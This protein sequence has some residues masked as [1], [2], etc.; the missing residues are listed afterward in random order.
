MSALRIAWFAPNAGNWVTFRMEHQMANALVD[1]GHDV[2]MVQCDEV[3]NAYCQVMAPAGLAAT[4]SDRDKKVVCRECRFAAGL[5]RDAARYRTAQLSEF[6]QP[7]D[8]VQADATVLAQTDETWRDLV[9]AGIPLGR[10]ASYT[11]MLH[12]KRFT[13]ADRPESWAEYRADLR[14]AFLLSAATPR[15]RDAFTPTHAAVYN[16]LYPANRVFA[17][18]MLASGVTL[19][20]L[21]AGPSVRYRYQ[22]VAV[23]DGIRASQTTVDSP[24]FRESL[25]VPLSP[26]EVDAVEAHVAALMA[27]SDPWVYSA[28]SGRRGANEILAF[29]G[30]RADA[31]VVTVLVGSPDETRS[32]LLVDAEYHRD[33]ERGYSDAHEY[34]AACVAL[35][36]R[37]P[38]VDFVI[39]LHPRLAPN[40]RDRVTSSDLQGLYDVLDDLPSNA[41]VNHPTDGLSLYDLV[42]VSAAAINQSS[43]AGLEFLAFGHPVLQ[44]DP[45]RLGAYPPEFAYPVARDDPVGF[46]AALD[47][48][49]AAGPDLRHSVDAF[50]WFAALQVRSVVA[51]EPLSDPASALPSAPATSEPAGASG[52]RRLVAAVLPGSVKTA[53]ARRIVRRQR[54]VDLGPP[55][56][57]PA[58]SAALLS[59]VRAARIEGDVWLPD[60]TYPDPPSDEIAESEAVQSAVARLRT[61][62]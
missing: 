40:K 50:R 52:G 10:Y 59:E 19:L 37:R 25:Q 28:A 31:P 24:S 6:L 2:L 61:R 34:L 30:V 42:L 48:A 12:H 60:M 55:T 3:L 23:Y 22:T 26:R 43:S 21:A 20:N 51:L 15:I 57:D 53:I 33:P 58:A 13:V 8:Y 18:T 32:A 36:R 45:V 49:L 62:L 1:A 14:N 4:S 7:A 54:R 44:Y 35:A 16:A 47:A 5:A 56:M 41:V 29:L 9:V 39:R 11:T 27:G 17:E 46:D 38:D